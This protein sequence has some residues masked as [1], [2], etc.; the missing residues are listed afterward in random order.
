MHASKGVLTITDT[1]NNSH[2]IYSRNT[3]H[4]SCLPSK[5]EAIASHV[6][7]HTAS[8]SGQIF[9]PLID[10]C[11]LATHLPL[12]NSSLTFLK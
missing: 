11:P 1:Q 4:G 8:Q 2:S 10:F 9:S 7:F 5:Q 12:T 6:P 3:T